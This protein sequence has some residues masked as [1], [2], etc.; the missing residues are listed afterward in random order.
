VSAQVQGR[1]V[2]IYDDMIRTGGSLLNAARAYQDAGARRLFVITTHGLFPGDALP[3]L[4]ASGL[5]SAIVATDSHPRA[6]LLAG[7]SLQIEP[8][9]P[10]L[11]AALKMPQAG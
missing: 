6:R 5:F 3:R 11:A 2:V 10:L 8:I 1:D 9:A 4:E 7:P